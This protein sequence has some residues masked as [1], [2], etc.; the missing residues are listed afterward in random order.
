MKKTAQALML[1]LLVVLP[2]APTGPTAIFVNSY[3]GLG[4]PAGQWTE[5]D[6]T[7]HGV[8]PDAQAAFVSGLLL[9]TH[10]TTPQICDLTIY[11]RKPGDTAE[12][13]YVGQAIEAHVSGGQRSGFAAWVALLGGKFQYK[14]GRNT[15][16]QWPSE[17][18]YGV[19]LRLQAYE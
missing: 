4:P 3:A 13:N 6:L 12:P 8:P 11:F 17:C 5:V 16:G 15:F 18:A 2:S 19:N 10:G 7:P 1:G 14:W 9:V